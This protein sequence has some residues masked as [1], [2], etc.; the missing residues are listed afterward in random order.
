MPPSGPTDGVHLWQVTFADLLTD[1]IRAVEHG[2]HGSD[3][4][5]ARSRRALELQR[6]GLTCCG[7]RCYLFRRH[8]HI[9]FL[10]RSVC[11]NSWE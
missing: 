3:R 6:L 1:H 5:A 9:S 2:A 11:T 4:L 10:H 8:G 7:Q